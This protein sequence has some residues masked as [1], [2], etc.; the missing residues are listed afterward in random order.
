MTTS[1]AIRSALTQGGFHADIATMRS[2]STTLDQQVV[3]LILDD[4]THLIAKATSRDSGGRLHAEADGLH[5]LREPGILLIPRVHALCDTD[6][7]TVLLMD[8]LRPAPTRIDDDAVWSRFGRELA[9]HHQS[10]PPAPY[11]WHRNNFLGPTPQPNAQSDDWVYFNATFR[12]GY[13]I[14]LAK[15]NGHLTRHESESLHRV[16]DRLPD[17]I[18]C[19]PAPA[20]LHGDLWSGNAMTTIDPQT[21]TP[22]IAVIDPAV[23]IGDAWADIAMMRLFGGFPIP[24]LNA[25]REANEDHDQLEQRIAIYQLYHALNHLNIFGPSYMSSTMSIAQQLLKM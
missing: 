3:D 15:T 13:Q 22:R 12:I 2:I 24:C 18:P 21:K 25:Y 20:R 16:M 4:D 17:F 7:H 8:K 10:T 11:G 23:S 1:D 19:N 6:H 5:A 14:E 9:E